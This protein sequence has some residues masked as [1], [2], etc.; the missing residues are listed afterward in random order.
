MHFASIDCGTSTSRV[1][2]VNENGNILGKGVRGVGVR[3]TS[4][5][6]SRDVL[7]EGLREAFHEALE[8]ASLQL[9]DIDFAISA[10]M[11]TSE[12]GLI[13]IPHLI[14]PVGVDD[15]ADHLVRVED[16]DVFPIDIPIYFIPGIKNNCPYGDMPHEDVGLLD[17][18]RGEEAQVA[19]ILRNSQGMEQIVTVLSSHTKFIPTD[20][21]GKILGSSTTLSGQIYQAIKKE[22]FL[23]KSISPDGTPEPEG[24][25]DSAILDNAWK[26]VRKTGFLRTLMMCRFLDVLMESKWYERNFFFDA[27]I[28]VEDMKAIEQFQE[29]GF[30][31]NTKIFFVG[32]QQRCKIYEY[33]LRTHMNWTSE[34]VLI[35]GAAEIDSLNIQG[36]IHIAEKAGILN[37]QVE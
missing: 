5:S 6:G 36:S 1:Y 11:I 37:S 2:I 17:L 18:M 34:I 15:L 9:P 23:G 26:W 29:L 19:G 20:K 21:D 10:G 33:I 7:K 28:A 4:I 27:A 16:K 22:T 31:V 14:A 24:F 13:E 8:E 32:N 12:I 30:P 35:H 3:D 25:F